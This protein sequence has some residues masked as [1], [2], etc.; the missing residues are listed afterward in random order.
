MLD[1]VLECPFARFK[2]LTLKRDELLKTE[3]IK[4]LSSRLG[5]FLSPKF[6]VKVSF[7]CRSS[8]CS[9]LCSMCQVNNIGRLKF[10]DVT[11]HL[12]SFTFWWV[13]F[14]VVNCSQ[15]MFVAIILVLSVFLRLEEEYWFYGFFYRKYY[16]FRRCFDLQ[17]KVSKIAVWTNFFWARELT[18]SCAAFSL[19]N[20]FLTLKK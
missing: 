17:A 6:S 20:D 13:S 19:V 10:L 1:R 16:S 15:T 14:L 2:N 5:A 12:L 9:R 8:E 4:S 3:G 18:R 7:E 11:Q